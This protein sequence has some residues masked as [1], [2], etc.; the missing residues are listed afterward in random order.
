MKKTDM[1]LQA[2]RKKL[3]QLESEPS[4]GDVLTAPWSTP[5]SAP[6]ARRQSSRNPASRPAY[7]ENAA[8]TP[9]SYPT[10]PSSKDVSPQATAIE[11]L[12]QRS[13]NQAHSTHSVHGERRADNLIAQEIYRLEIHAQSINERSQ[14]Q[15][16]ELLAM[17]RSAQQAALAFRRQGI[18]EHPQLE[19]ISELLATQSTTT[20]PQIERDSQG[21][22][23]VTQSLVDLHRAEQEALSNAETL[24][25]RMP[26]SNHTEPFG[27][28]EPADSF[29]PFSEDIENGPNLD[30]YELASTRPS[31]REDA[32]LP[33]K[34]RRMPGLLWIFSLFRM[35]SPMVKRRPNS[36]QG[37]AHSNRLST[38][39]MGNS[40]AAIPSSN[41]FS[42]LDG[43]IWFSAAA[44]TRIVLEAIVLSYPLL[45]MPL[46][47]ILFSAISFSIYRVVVSQSSSWTSAYR[48]GVVLL[49]LFLG[50]SLS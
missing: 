41:R 39:G 23:S 35:F 25:N 15:A 34:T 31:K 14:Q 1:E 3:R 46:L 37:N 28:H 49:G 8:Y 4:A 7:F 26:F 30:D 6:A 18:H 29:I 24:R 48:L 5:V 27:I 20:V 16:A 36:R 42:W 43:T 47:L 32:S 45:R 44:I 40:Q 19:I 11:A 12:K 17:K 9:Q 38:A 10:G 2:I 22:F 50:S 13:T 33:R 21:Y